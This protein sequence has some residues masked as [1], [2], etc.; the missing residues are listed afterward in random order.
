MIMM[1]MSVLQGFGETSLSFSVHGG[2]NITGLRLVDFSN[3]TA[4]AFL[5][6]WQGLDNAKWSGSSSGHNRITVSNSQHLLL[7][8]LIDSRWLSVTCG[9][10]TN[11][12]FTQI[13][14][15]DSAWP[16]VF[17]SNEYRR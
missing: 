7:V 13:T 6:A 4:K 9:R 3:Q 15:A 14:H 5:K 2:M 12:A 11:A 10:Y 16:S 1:M 8:L 17:R